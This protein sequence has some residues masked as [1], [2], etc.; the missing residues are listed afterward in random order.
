MIEF[1]NIFFSFS[2]LSLTV[3]FYICAA[4]HK[5]KINLNPL[6]TIDKILQAKRHA[7]L[8]PVDAPFPS[9]GPMAVRNCV[10]AVGASIRSPMMSAGVGRGG[11]GGDNPLAKA[12]GVTCAAPSV[13]SY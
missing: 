2:N 8:R 7:Y 10:E 3:N 6:T 4:D 13:P 11:G 5:V 9:T 1:C 12:V